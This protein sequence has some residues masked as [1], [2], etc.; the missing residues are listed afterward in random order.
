MVCGAP[1]I[2]GGSIGFPFLLSP[3]FLQAGAHDGAGA[4]RT[5]K[6]RIQGF[7]G[8]RIQVNFTRQTNDE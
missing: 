2:D 8:S 5:I 3:A 1:C 7:K 4:D 6:K